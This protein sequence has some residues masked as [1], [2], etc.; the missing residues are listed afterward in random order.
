MKEHE[1]VY[2]AFANNPVWFVDLFGNNWYISNKS[3]SD[4]QPVWL[5]NEKLANEVFGENGFIDLGE[6]LLPELIVT[7]EGSSIGDSYNVP[8]Y[9]INAK[10]EYGQKEIEGDEHNPRI[11]EYHST[12]QNPETGKP[13]TDDETAWC[14]SF[15]N[16]NLVKSGYPSNENKYNA[17]A[18]SYNKWNPQYT[19]LDK[20]ALGAMAVIKTG[21][22]YHVTFVIGING[23]F[24]H[25]YG[26][27]Q[28]NQVK[29]STYKKIKVEGYY[30]PVGLSPNYNVPI[31]KFNFNNKNSE[32]TR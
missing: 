15:C 2:A 22:N 1:S 16:W 30:V 25:G 3:D 20:P 26:G 11:L 13:Y 29:V 27:N 4:S 18:T 21:K 6:N 23:D 5:P 14:A 19:K 28:G 12:T 24:I 31:I 10:G 7:P 32:S 9:L 17:T 8:N